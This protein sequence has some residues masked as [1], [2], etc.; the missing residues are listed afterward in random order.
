M[1]DQKKILSLYGATLWG[2][3]LRSRGDPDNQSRVNY[4]L[5]KINVNC[6]PSWGGVR[7]SYPRIIACPCKP[8][9]YAL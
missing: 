1:G 9:H 4:I 3:L 2:N 5:M 7:E 8:S 6:A